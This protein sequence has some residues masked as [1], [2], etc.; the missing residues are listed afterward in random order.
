MTNTASRTKALSGALLLVATFSLAAC[1]SDQTVTRTTTTER[2]TTSSAPVGDS[3]TS[4]TTTTRQVSP[5]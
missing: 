3:S 5:Q 1:G 4:T 2:T